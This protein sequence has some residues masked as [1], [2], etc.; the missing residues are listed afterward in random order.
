MNNP[1]KLAKWREGA[2]LTL[3]AA[4]AEVGVSHASWCSWESGVRAP[5]LEKALRIEAL[6]KGVVP[7]EG[8]GFDGAVLRDM[9]AVLA[10]PS[11]AANDNALAEAS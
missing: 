4:S 11:R 7:I 3:V 10:L 6:T 1:Q 9:A 5:S 2:G 8:W